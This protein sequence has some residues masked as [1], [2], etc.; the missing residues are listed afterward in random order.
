MSETA[1]RG[2]RPTNDL[3]WRHVDLASGWLRVNQSK[4]D[5]GVRDVRLLPVLREE[6]AAWKATVNHSTPND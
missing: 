6:L 1:G 5:A 4:T 3:R 2:R